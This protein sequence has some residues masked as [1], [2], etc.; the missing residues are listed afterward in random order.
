MR[1][2][3]QDKVTVRWIDA[4]T[5]E[6]FADRMNDPSLP[7]GE[8]ILEVARAIGRL[9]A[10]RQI[11]AKRGLLTAVAAELQA[12][13]EE[14]S[15]SGTPQPGDELTLNGVTYSYDGSTDDGEHFTRLKGESCEEALVSLRR[16]SAAADWML[17]QL[18]RY[19]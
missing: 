14:R 11:E 15:L 1:E 18:I 8:G 7:P 19:A 13:T 5:G 9:M 12:E 2:T 17:R 4:K 3:K 6:D 10:A 16:G